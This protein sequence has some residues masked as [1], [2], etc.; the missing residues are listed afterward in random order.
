MFG[1]SW[2]HLIVLVIILLIFGPK[3]L[4]EVGHTL[5]KALRNLKDGLEGVK[6]A[7]F[8][9]LDNAETVKP[10]PPTPK[11]DAKVQNESPDQQEASNEIHTDKKENS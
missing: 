2:Q 10:Q 8:S 11:I 3:R 6:N 4:P 5:G 9:K 7:D 1:I